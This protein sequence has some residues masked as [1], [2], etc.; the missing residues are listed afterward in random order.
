MGN[1]LYLTMNW[2]S[3][4]SLE[5][6]L[7]QGDSYG[8]YNFILVDPPAKNKAFML[9]KEKEN[10]CVVSIIPDISGDGAFAMM[11]YRKSPYAA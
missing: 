11:E 4:N 10:S 2:H 1:S 6:D 9:L 7:P 5:N 8:P 3:H